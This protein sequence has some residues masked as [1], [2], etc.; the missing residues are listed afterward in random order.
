MKPNSSG[1]DIVPSMELFD[2]VS[3]TF[4]QLVTNS[5]GFPADMKETIS[6]DP[7]EE[8]IPADL[9]ETTSQCDDGKA[10]TNSVNSAT[11][12][13]DEMGPAKSSHDP[14]HNDVAD[15]VRN[16]TVS[17]KDESDLSLTGAESETDTSK[18]V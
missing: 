11:A 9:R 2:E 4:P 6:A 16:D 10:Q 13:D 15:N 12:T 5:K 3:A 18:M 7:K 1:N 17:D 8:G 14:L